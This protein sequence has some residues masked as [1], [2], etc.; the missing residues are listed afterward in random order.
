MR[1]RAAAGREPNASIMNFTVPILGN[2]LRQTLPLK[3]QLP[4]PPTL[5]RL[6]V[7]T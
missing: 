2:N 3:P 7:V 6:T 4:R 5:L 1:N